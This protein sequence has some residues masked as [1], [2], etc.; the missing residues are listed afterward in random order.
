VLALCGEESGC[1][2]W[3]TYLPFAELHRRGHVAE[4]APLDKSPEVFPLVAAG[5][6]EAVILPRLAWSVEHQAEARGWIR[7]LH[8]A[9]LAVIYEVDDDVFT[10]QIAARQKATT[11]THK[12]LE[13]LKQ[14]RLDRI[15]AMR[16]C[17]GVTVSNDNLA[18]VVK[19]YTDAPVMVVPNAIDTRW[20]RRVLHGVKRI[21]PPLTIGWA[22]GARY[23]QDLEPIAEA[24][25]TIAQRYPAVTFVVQGFLPDV[26]VEAVPYDRVRRLPWLPL[27][28]YPRALLNVDIGCANVADIQF[29]RCK[30]PIKLWEYTMAG[31]VSVVSEALYGAVGTDGEDCLIAETASEWEAA[32]VRLIESSELRRRLWRQQRRRVAEQHS[33]EKNVHKWLEAW[34]Q[35]IQHARRPRLLLAG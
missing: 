30:T 16:L 4:W 9:G 22:G 2:L 24:W 26:L 6:F 34:S 21:V 35:I 27:E 12:E 25:R 1:S 29:N 31:A 20:W 15:S 33:L 23:E 10:P 8:R 18:R 3:R 7:S 14:E 13:Q 32:L 28:E 5:V 11:E 19:Q 17:D